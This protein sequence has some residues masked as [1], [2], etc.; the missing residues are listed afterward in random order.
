MTTEEQELLRRVTTHDEAAFDTLYAHYAPQV[1]SYLSRR[2]GHRP[3]LID[4]VLQEVML[5]LWQRAV[6]VPPTVPLVAWL[7]GVARHKMFKALACASA[8]NVSKMVEEPQ[9]VDAPEIALL[10]QDDRRS[11]ARGLDAL[12]HGERIALTLLLQGASYQEIA[13]A[14]GD[15]VSTIRTRVSRACQRL[16]TRIAALESGY[17]PPT[18]AE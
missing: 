14:T 11:V 6:Q 5:A 7:C 15:P 2:L 16:R 4:D 18:S 10:R 9:E 17:E 1:C 8:P 3:E 13:L 12:P